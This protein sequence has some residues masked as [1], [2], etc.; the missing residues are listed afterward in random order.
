MMRRSLFI[1]IS[2]LLSLAHSVAETVTIK[3]TKKYLNIPVSHAVQREVIEIAVEG[4]KERSFEIRLA[5]ENPDYWVFCD[6]STFRGKTLDISFPSPG[7]GLSQIYQSDEIAGQDSLYS[8][9]NRPQFHFSSRRG[10]NNDPNGL[11]YFEGEYHL[12]YQHNPYEREWGNMH[13]GH[14]VSKDLI[15]WEELPVALYPDEHGTV[16]S[17]SV[18]IDYP[19]S[20][21]FNKGN[22]PAMVALYTA[23][24]PDR[25]VQCVAYS[26]D[27][28]RTWSKY[29]HNPVIDSKEKWNSKDTRDPKVFW[30]E[31]DKKWV[32]VLNERDGHSI[33]NSTDLKEWTYKSHVTGFWEC[34]ELFELP[35]DNDASDKKW[36]MYGASG[37]YMIGSF[38]GEEFVPESGKHYYTS[39]S[40]Y[41]GQTFNN[42]PK[43]DGR[44]IQISWG[45]IPSGDM[46]FNMLMLMPAELT[47]RT[48]G[49]G[50]RMFGY[51]VEETNL[52]TDKSRKWEDLGAEEANRVIN[53][54]KDESLLRI[55]FTLSLSH[56]TDAGLDLDGQSLLNYDMNF[57]T[58]NGIFYSPDEMTSMELSAD[59]FIDKT[60]VEIFIDN[61][62]YSCSFG[63][64]T[65]DRKQGFNFRG[66][67]IRIKNLELS[68]LRSIWK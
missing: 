57:N 16:F 31:P 23:D 6:I 41:A 68:T 54:F 43:S 59:I 34:P 60:S 48:T 37:T 35:V 61:G 18:V 15:H 19:N 33:Y 26:T 56:A 8:E 58:V 22:S 3:A 21:G 9:E 10:W 13:W 50:V 30:Y 2:L 67:N 12:F 36:V 29:A 53:E 66:N 25:Q 42:I 63:K 45:R 55:R 27:R 44:R 4:R 65:P 49:K 62:A 38:N 1:L 46:P 20:A 32:M 24:S 51:P 7:N 28:G 11:V 64:K 5:P 39:G 40:G 14:A 52:L 47:L 17:G